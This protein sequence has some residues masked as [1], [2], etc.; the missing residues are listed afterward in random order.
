M[1]KYIVIVS[2]LPIFLTSKSFGQTQISDEYVQ[3]IITTGRQY[4]VAILK[5][6]TNKSLSE[7]SIENEQMSHLKYL[8]RLRDQGK[9]PIF[10]PFYNSGDLLGFCIFNSTSEGEVKSL[11]DGD[12]HVKSGYMTY[13]V[14]SWFGIPGDSLPKE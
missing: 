9:L 8:F 6:G 2:G 4:I 13:E 12:P 10:G 3:H 5:T 7:D 1:K 11:M 14:Y